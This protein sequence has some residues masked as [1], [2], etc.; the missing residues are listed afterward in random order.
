MIMDGLLNTAERG[1]DV[2]LGQD[3]GGVGGGCYHASRA[4]SNSDRQDFGRSVG[5]RAGLAVV[6]SVCEAAG[7]EDVAHVKPTIVPAAAAARWT[8]ER[9][10]VGIHYGHLEWTLIGGF[11]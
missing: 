6:A 9:Y 2:G 1:D 7:I 11:E 10:G 3:A 4:A 5:D 8:F